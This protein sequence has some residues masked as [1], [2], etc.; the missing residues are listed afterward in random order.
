MWKKQCACSTTIELACPI[1]FKKDASSWL[2]VMLNLCLKIT[3]PEPVYAHKRHA[4][5][6]KHV[7]Q[8]VSWLCI[9]FTLPL[10]TV[11]MN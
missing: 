10:S 6:K 8:T 5:K 9:G 7:H 11:H 3:R 1:S 2:S 4:Y